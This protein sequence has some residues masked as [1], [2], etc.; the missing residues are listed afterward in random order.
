MKYFISI[1]FALIFLAQ[2]SAQIDG[3]LLF[4]QKC[5]ACHSVDKTLVGPA[6]KDIE[7]RRDSAWIY[8][9]INSSQEMIESGDPIANELFQAYNQIMMPDQKLANDEIGAILSYIKLESLENTKVSSIER[10]IPY[11]ASNNNRPMRFTD[12]MFWVP[13]TLSVIFLILIINYWIEI[14]D[15]KKNL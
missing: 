7:K 9:F 1:I 12:F 15:M 14:E 5:K 11:W 8:T 13:F 2:T 6:L 3:K 10:P 4:K